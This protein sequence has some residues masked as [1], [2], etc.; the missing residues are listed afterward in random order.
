[1]PGSN[2]AKVD[3]DKEDL[4]LKTATV[5]IAKDAR[6]NGILTF[7][8]P[9]TSER[10]LT[11]NNSSLTIHFKD[12]QSNPNQTPRSVIGAKAAKPKSSPGI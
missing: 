7:V 4:V 1:M 3:L 10:I 11:N 2:G 6:V 12:S 8:L 9:G 5:P